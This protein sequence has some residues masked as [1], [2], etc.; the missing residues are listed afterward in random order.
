MLFRSVVSFD[1]ELA[2]FWD[3]KWTGAPL[4][5]LA[6]KGISLV[7]YLLVLVEYAPIP[8]DQ[9]SKPSESLFMSS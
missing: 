7:L 9:V 4:L 3:M 1:R 8:T 5:F 2:C 6:N